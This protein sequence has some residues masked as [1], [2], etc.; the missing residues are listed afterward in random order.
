MVPRPK[1]LANALV[2]L[3]AA[4]QACGTLGRMPAFNRSLQVAAAAGSSRPA[5]T[6]SMYDY[7]EYLHQVA[8]DWYALGAEEVLK[9]GPEAIPS[10][11]V[12]ARR[13]RAA[14]DE[15]MESLRHAPA[16]AYAWSLLVTAQYDLGHRRGALSA[17]R[18][19]QQH[20]TKDARTAFRR[21]LL[22]ARMISGP[23]FDTASRETPV[24]DLVLANLEIMQVHSPNRL[25]YV[26]QTYP[27][28]ARFA[29]TEDEAG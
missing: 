13:I 24:S 22:L 14:R 2:L 21:T 5:V 4:W 8:H 18:A 3:F 20:A 23:C 16:N 26:L 11:R 6:Q 17:L 12:L 7:S 10:Q 25:R 29:A 27:D 1:C 9:G 15:P 28:L 19:S